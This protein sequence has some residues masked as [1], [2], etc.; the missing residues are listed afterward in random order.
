VPY[1]TPAAKVRIFF[2][3]TELGEYLITQVSHQ[4]TNGNQYTSTF[5]AIAGDTHII[6]TPILP[7]PPCEPQLAIVRKNDDPQ[8]QGRVRVQFLW[9][10]GDN[11]TDWIR[12]MT[13]DAGS[14]DKTAKNRGFV[15]VPE[16]GDQV[17][18]G[19][20]DGN[21]S[22]PFVLG[23]LFHGKNSS[24][25]GGGKDNFVKTIQTRSGHTIEFDDEADGTHI[26]IRDTGGNEI[27]LDTKGKS[28]TITAT[29]NI[30]LKAKNIDL[31]ASENVSISA[32]ENVNTSAGE[33]IAQSA[34][35]DTTL[36][37]ENIHTIANEKISLVAKE[38]EAVAE[39]VTMDSS[40][41]DLLLSSAKK[42]D[43]QSSEKVR[44]F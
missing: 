27:C 12:V 34:M 25:Q 19:F 37:A 16:V 9:Q 13:P 42:I 28:I 3:E 36:T 41:E 1:L 23:S 18:V 40:K 39:K 31:T 21:A 8:R 10:K 35:K 7:A 14:G 20:Q 33:S 5:K 11:M 15:F 4:L 17:M 43:I 24:A 30:T 6:P 2:G 32:G 22:A 38:L 44:L 26:I 29:E